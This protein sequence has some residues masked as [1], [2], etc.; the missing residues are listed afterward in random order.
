MNS[1]S[2]LTAFAVKAILITGIIVIIVSAIGIALKQKLTNWFDS[3]SGSN[4]FTPQWDRL[5][6]FFAKRLLTEA[7]KKL[8]LR[9]KTAL[10]DHFILCQVA[11]RA[12]VDAKTGENVQ[13]W[14]NKI[15]NKYVDFVICNPNFSVAAV[16]EL[17]DRTHDTT[18]RQRKDEE[19]DTA[20]NAAGIRVI[21]WRARDLPSTFDIARC[22]QKTPL[23][24][25][26]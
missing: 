6:K 13:V 20:L 14:I 21:R 1:L 26:P 2:D 17:D 9:M 25:N 23:D 12:L 18:E 7:E 22:F 3:F 11:L 4:N 10:P 24:M 16:I 8:F 15:Q 5:P 19:K